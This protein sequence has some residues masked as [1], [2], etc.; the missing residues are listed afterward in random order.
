M[1]KFLNLANLAVINQLQIE[2]RQ[3]LNVLSGETGS[4]KSIIVDA[5][6]LLL[7]ERASQDMIWTGE[8]RAFVEAVRAADAAL[9]RTD[10]E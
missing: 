3:G 8:M 6:G 5:L 1:L 10:K 2:F 9:T 7:G 4:G